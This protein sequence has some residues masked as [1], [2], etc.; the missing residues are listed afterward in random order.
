MRRKS[1]GKLFFQAFLLLVLLFG[2]VYLI[3]MK[4]GLFALAGLAALLILLLLSTVGLATYKTRGNK[5]L[6][7]TFLLNA[8]NV[9]CLWYFFNSFYLVLMVASLLGLWV[10]MPRRAQKCQEEGGSCETSCEPKVSSPPP[11]KVTEAKVQPKIT[12][13]V[14]PKR[15]TSAKVKFTP[16]KYVASKRSNVYHEPKCEWANNIKKDHRIWFEA[17]EKAW[18]KGYKAHGC[19]KE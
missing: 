4:S 11:Q 14:E 17:K 16:G 8:L 2:L 3:T 1:V 12:K 10:S 13:V 18:E 5:I 9:L 19:V 7:F 15:A 6:F